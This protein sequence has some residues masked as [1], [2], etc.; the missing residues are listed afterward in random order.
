MLKDEKKKNVETQMTIFSPPKALKFIIYKYKCTCDLLSMA[1]LSHIIVKNI[2][3]N[4]LTF[5]RFIFKYG[6]RKDKI[7]LCEIHQSYNITL[8]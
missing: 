1:W 5:A 6:S 2:Y 8:C 4:I 3:Q 7:T